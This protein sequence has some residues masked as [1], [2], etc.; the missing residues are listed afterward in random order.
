LPAIDDD[1]DDEFA[2]VLEHHARAHSFPPW[3]SAPPPPPVPV[4]VPVPASNAG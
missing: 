3:G 2:E 1:D 4:P